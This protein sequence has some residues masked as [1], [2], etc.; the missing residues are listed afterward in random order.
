MEWEKND[1]LIT[2]NWPNGYKYEKRI[3]LLLHHTDKNISWNYIPRCIRRLN[4]EASKD[5]LEVY[6][7]DFGVGKDFLN[8]TQK[9]TLIV[10]NSSSSRYS[11][12]KKRE[13]IDQI[14]YLQHIHLTKNLH[15]CIY[16]SVYVSS[17]KY[18]KARQPMLK[19]ISRLTFFTKMTTKAA[20]KHVMPH[21]NHRL[22]RGT[23]KE[24]DAAKC[25]RGLR[26]TWALR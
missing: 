23:E 13:D 21:H 22:K 10:K 25:W 6:L 3:N 24:T 18:I 2:A 19:T 14:R 15:V 5:N 26:S 1:L 12:W 4:N 16:V 17:P 7:H 11:T 20:N 8:R 9:K